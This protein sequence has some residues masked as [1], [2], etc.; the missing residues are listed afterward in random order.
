MAPARSVDVGH[1]YKNFN[2]GDN[3]FV[4]AG[5][6]YRI[7]VQPNARELLELLSKSGVGNVITEAPRA[8]ANEEEGLAR[9]DSFDHVQSSTTPDIEQSWRTN[10]QALEKLRECLKMLDPFFTSHTNL[11]QDFLELESRLRV[12]VSKVHEETVLLVRHSPQPNYSLC[13]SF[14]KDAIEALK[15]PTEE[16]YHH[17]LFLGRERAF[18]CSSPRK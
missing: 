11:R 5:D 14:P 12:D 2:I 1:K 13:R 7:L 9:V 16:G 8:P 18:A 15:E 6:I 10:E 4:I 17:G 3:A